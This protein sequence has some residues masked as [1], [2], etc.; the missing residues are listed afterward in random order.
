MTRKL[1]LYTFC[2]AVDKSCDIIHKLQMCSDVWEEFQKFV[3]FKAKCLSLYTD[4][5]AA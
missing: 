4:T 5:R 2:E 3:A 1:V